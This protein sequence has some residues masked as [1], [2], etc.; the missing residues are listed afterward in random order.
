MDEFE[1]IRRYFDRQQDSQD[2]RIGIGDDGAVLVPPV[3]TEIVIVIDTLVGDV[4]FPGD[5]DAADI[6]YRAVAVNLSDIAAMGSSPRWMT[7][8]LTLVDADPA[9][10]GEFSRGMFDAADQFGVSLVGGDTTQG[11][12]LVVTVQL[13]GTV[14][15]GAA[16]TRCGA[17]EGDLIFVTGTPGDAA[18]GLQILK[19]SSVESDAGNA[20]IGRFCRPDPRVAFGG[21]IASMASAAIDISDG[22]YGDLQKVLQASGVAGTLELDRLPVSSAMQNLFERDAAIDFALGGGDDYE[23]C[24]TAKPAVEQQVM[25][26]AA[27]I[28]LRVSRVGQ[29]SSGAGLVCSDGGQVIEYQ[30]AGYRHFEEAA[31]A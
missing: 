2:I 25:E 8:A 4:H 15:P 7:L 23:L 19:R 24:F 31:G 17:A 30:H 22:L 10:L 5:L 13:T 27:A 6:G 20:L 28:G 11:S 16:M 21:M 14:M 12:Q 9:W 29:V 3:G 1:L 26:T 18:A